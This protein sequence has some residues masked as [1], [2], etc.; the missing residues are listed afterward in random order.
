MFERFT[1]EAR[2]VVVHAQEEARRLHHHHIGTEHLLL[3]AAR[4]AGLPRAVILSRHGL[5]RDAAIEAIR[6][7]TA[8]DGLDADG[9]RHGRHRPGRRPQQRGGDLRA[10]RPRRPRSR[11]R[12]EGPHPVHA[13]ARRRCWSS[14]LREAIALKSRSIADGHIALGL[15]R[16]GEGLAAKVIA[17]SRDRPGHAPPGDHERTGG[18]TSRSRTSA[19]IAASP[20]AIAAPANTVCSW[21]RIAASVAAS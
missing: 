12:A 19:A 4:P 6:T 2:E 21:V 3:G 7:F 16:E 17:R 10:G 15:L 13:A 5:T 20:A 14:R 18:L 8:G 9:P 1:E 11:T